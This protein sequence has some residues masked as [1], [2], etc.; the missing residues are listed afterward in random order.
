MFS[1]L[2]NLSNTN[3]S[4]TDIISLEH[5]LNDKS[6]VL[7]VFALFVL[8]IIPTVV[9]SH[10]VMMHQNLTMSGLSTTLIFL[11]SLIYIV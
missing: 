7:V 8:I 9:M 5:K 2:I 10:F 1:F 6:R 4:Y 3:Q 11:I